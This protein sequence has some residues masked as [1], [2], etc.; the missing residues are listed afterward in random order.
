MK[1]KVPNQAVF[2]VWKLISNIIALFYQALFVKKYTDWNM[3][4]YFKG[5][6]TKKTTYLKLKI[7]RWHCSNLL[8]TTEDR[9]IVSMKL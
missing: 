9:C 5:F 3:Y 2:F 8:P 4:I 6:Q 1:S 7:L